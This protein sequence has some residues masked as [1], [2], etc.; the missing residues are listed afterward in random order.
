MEILYILLGWSLGILSPAIIDYISNNYQAARIK[1]AVFA[2]FEDI[3]MRLI[4][5]V[6]KIYTFRGLVDLEFVK[7]ALRQSEGYSGNESVESFNMLRGLD[8]DQLCMRIAQ[9]NDHAEGEGRGLNIKVVNTSI[10]DSCLV[11]IN[12]LKP[13]YLT[14]LLEVKFHINVL[15]Q[16]I[17]SLNGYFKMTFDPSLSERNQ[18]IISINM[19]D[20][21]NFIAKRCKIIV[22]RIRK[23]TL[24]NTR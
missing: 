8:D 16:E 15:N 5:V 19:N 4:M 9:I 12:L 17:V 22:E 3:A 18:R 6:F 20:A 7:W 2:E 23:L 11:N 14:L 24:E 1:T 21:E 10:L 13:K